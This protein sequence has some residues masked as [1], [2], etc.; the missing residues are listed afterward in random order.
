[1]L[2]LLPPGI[3]MNIRNFQFVPDHSHFDVIKKEYKVLGMLELVRVQ[4]DK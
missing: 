2:S 4:V 1:M 3:R